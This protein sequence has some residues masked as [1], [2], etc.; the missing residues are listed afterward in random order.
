MCGNNTVWLNYQQFF[1]KTQI[2]R[3]RNCVATKLQTSRTCSISLRSWETIKCTHKRKYNAAYREHCSIWWIK[4]L[5]IIR[6]HSSRPGWKSS[7]R[8]RQA[9]ATV[10][11]VHTITY[12]AQPLNWRLT[13]PCG[14]PPVD[15]RP[16]GPRTAYRG[17]TLRVQ[18]RI[19]WPAMQYTLTWMLNIL[20]IIRAPW[21][22]PVYDKRGRAT[23]RHLVKRRGVFG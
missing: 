5:R 6:T 17:Q 2:Y 13:Q 10:P 20:V 11:V 21:A 22:T 18:E 14:A 7:H 23:S 1:R 8:A 4:L 12:T 15:G 16:G 19:S 9:D 3:R